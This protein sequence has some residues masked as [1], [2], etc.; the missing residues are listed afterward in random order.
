MLSQGGEMKVNKLTAVFCAVI[1]IIGMTAC[2]GGGGKYAD[3]KPVVQKFNA[4][5]EKFIA[6][7]EKADSAEKVAAAMNDFAK[8][9]GDLKTQME[10][11]EEKYPELK[12][13]SDPPEE[14]AEDGKKMSDLMMQLGSVMMKAMQYQDDEAVK[15]AMEK[16]QKIMQ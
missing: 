5:T 12:D 9:M 7:M 3:L 8:I 1:F 11:M 2:G 14:L 15:D 16:F 10:K 4:N 13:M 6:T